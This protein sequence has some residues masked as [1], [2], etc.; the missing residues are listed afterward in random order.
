VFFYVSAHPTD[1]AGGMFSGHLSLCAYDPHSAHPA[2][3]DLMICGAIEKH[4]LTEVE[5]FSNQLAVNF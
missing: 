1:G 5:A 4:S 3:C 2:L